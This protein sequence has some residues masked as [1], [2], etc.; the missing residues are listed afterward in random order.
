MLFQGHGPLESVRVPGVEPKLIQEASDS[1]T[2]SRHFT[3]PRQA[4]VY[5]CDTAHSRDERQ[6]RIMDKNRTEGMTHEIK[7]ATK[8]VAGKVTG[9]HAKEAA[10]HIEKNVGKMQ[11]EA[12]KAVDHARDE[13]KK[14]C[15]D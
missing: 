2:L 9:N 12:G 1:L 15:C 11:K 8:E 7:G 3:R 6:D 4:A 13:S 10:G 14:G 5:T